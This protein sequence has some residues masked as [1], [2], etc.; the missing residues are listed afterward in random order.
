MRYLA[1]VTAVLVTFLWSTSYIIIKFTLAGIPPLSFAS[2]RYVLTS[3]ILLA[4][5]VSRSKRAVKARVIQLRYIILAGLLG[6]TLAQGLQ[7]IALYMLP[8]VT[9]SLLLNFNSVFVLIL[10]YFLIREFPSNKQMIGIALALTG[11][12]IY[13]GQAELI[14]SDILGLIITVISGL[15]WAGYMVLVRYF[16][17]DGSSDVLSFTAVSITVGSLILLGISGVIEGYPNPDVRTWFSII[18]LSLINTGLAFVLWNY[19]L[20]YLKAYEQSILQN[21]MLIQIT[22]LSWVFLKAEAITF[23]NIIGIF[24]VFIGVLIVQIAGS[25]VKE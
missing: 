5:T 9:V 20:K 23:T 25:L 15:S 21:T 19:C 6:Y 4:L 2:Y 24:L 14:I 12:V 17:K 7:F 18:W 8:A 16:M 3:L 11:V 1:L 22:A 13:F 10:S